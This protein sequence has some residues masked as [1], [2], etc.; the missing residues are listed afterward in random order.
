MTRR[1]ILGTAQFGSNYGVANQIGKVN[2][3]QASKILEIA[4][5]HQITFLDTAIG[6]GLSENTLGSVGVSDCQVTT[7][8]PALPLECEDIFRWIQDQIQSSINRLRVHKL[9]GLLLHRPEQLFDSR[10][11]ELYAALLRARDE[12]FVC[13]IG[14]SIYN[15][16]ELNMLF[17]HMHFDIVQAPFNVFDHRIVT[18]GWAKRLQQSRVELHV[19]SIFLQGLLLMPSKNQPIYFN[20]WKELMHEWD[21][22][23]ISNNVSKVQACLSFALNMIDTAK[24][25]V[26]V[27]SAQQLQQVICMAKS[28]SKI[29]PSMLQ[30]EDEKLINP[31]LWRLS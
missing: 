27:D 23:T 14:V 19:R 29:I 6:Y 30:S 1:L 11:D 25:V 15:P 9:Y 20:P 31:S 13:K 18:S 21:N 26:G 16:M 24:I 17:E 8:L 2:I 4:R 12:A 5:R 3:Q 7:K 22:W 28:Q 10:G